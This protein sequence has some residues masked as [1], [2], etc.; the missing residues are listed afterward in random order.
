MNNQDG[1]SQIIILPKPIRKAMANKIWSPINIKKS[2]ITIK[3][4]SESQTKLFGENGIPF[5]KKGF[6]ENIYNLV[7]N[8][9]EGSSE[10]S[11]IKVRESKFG[12]KYD[13]LRMSDPLPLRPPTRSENPISLDPL[14]QNEVFSS[15][16]INNN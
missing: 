14:F 16:R 10:S 5:P 13:N 15:E 4:H 3:P 9:T 2:P 1:Y 6:I 8:D 7:L 11:P 12:C